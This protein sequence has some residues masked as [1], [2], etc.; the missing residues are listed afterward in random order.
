MGKILLLVSCTLICLALIFTS[1]LRTASAA[2][3]NPTGPVIG[4][5]IKGVS[6]NGDL[7]KLPYTKPKDIPLPPRPALG[8]Q[9]Q[10]Q[11]QPSVPL[12]DP[13]RQGALAPLSMPGLFRS[14]DGLGYVTWGAR[15]QPDATGDAG[16]NHYI[17]TLNTSLAVFD[18]NG[19]RLAAA[20]FN[21]WW[22]QPAQTGPCY[23]N[24]HHG[25]PIVVYDAAADRWLISDM[26]GASGQYYWCIAV[27]IS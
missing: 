20:T 24:S 4:P 10:P 7:R 1:D 26:A 5:S 15:L 9:R 11:L 16:P 12:R 25:N 3:P 6:F 21:N 8:S 27:S 23:N 13:V 2:P 18:K 22:N 17:Q 19:N 14:F